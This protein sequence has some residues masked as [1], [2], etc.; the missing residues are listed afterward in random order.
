MPTAT[1]SPPHS[2][3]LAR[4][5]TQCDRLITSPSSTC[6]WE[7]RSRFSYRLRLG[8][9]PCSPVALLAQDRESSLVSQLVTA[10]QPLRSPAASCPMRPAVDWSLFGAALS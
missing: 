3:Q 5:P 2:T 6:G 1:A 7:Y 10:L 4:T 9:L 8:V